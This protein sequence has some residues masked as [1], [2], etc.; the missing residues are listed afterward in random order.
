MGKKIAGP[1][2]I[3]SKER[4]KKTLK[5]G[6]TPGLRSIPTEDSL[7]V[8]FLTTTDDWHGFY[9][10]WLKD[11]PKPCT[12]DDCEGCQSDD[13]EER[14]RQ[15]RY[16]ANAYVVDD[17]KVQAILIPKTLAEQLVNYQAKYKGTLMDRDYEL[18]RTGSGKTGTKYMASPEP[19]SKMKLSRFE[20]K[21]LD[22]D[23]VLQSML[24]DEDDGD[25]DDEP[26][27]KSKSSKPKKSKKNPWDDEKPVS[28]PKKKKSASKSKSS[29]V[30]KSTVKRKV[31]R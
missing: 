24:G 25:E 11:G 17:Q 30:K 6:G 2:R 7:T 28:H 12:S 9:L 29:G 27:K 21:M 4:M 14:R 18:S 3:G 8:R 5:G 19:P 15:F 31:R 1:G 26:V 16:L 10:H 22:L 20:D 23:K 13:E